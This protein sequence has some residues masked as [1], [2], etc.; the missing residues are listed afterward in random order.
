MKAIVFPSGR[1]V[2][3]ERRFLDM[4]LSLAHEDPSGPQTTRARG[5]EYVVG[6][7]RRG[8]RL[9]L[10]RRPI[11]EAVGGAALRVHTVEIEVPRDRGRIEDAIAPPS[12]VELE[13]R[14]VGEPANGSV[15]KRNYIDVEVRRDVP[16][17]NDLASIGG[18]G[19]GHS[20]PPTP[21]RLPPPAVPPR[22]GRPC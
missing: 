13:R 22:C 18:I 20:L 1:P 8:V 17:E 10:V 6:R 3:C 15:C 5:D 19:P 12:W 4:D 14:S 11:V 7:R 21:A 9:D 16:R 2:E